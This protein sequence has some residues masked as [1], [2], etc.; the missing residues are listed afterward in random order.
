VRGGGSRADLAAFDAERVARAIATFPMPVWTGIGH[1]GD[2]SVAD[3]VANRAFVTPTEC[4]QELTRRL[5]EWW[6]S[7]QR[8][9]AAVA[10]GA[11]AV[12][13]TASSHDAAARL[14]LGMATRNQ[15]HRH[16]QRVDERTGRI[17]LQSR[18][19]LEEAMVALHQRTVRLGTRARNVCDREQDRV[20][21]WRRLL[22]AYDIDRQLE[23]GYTITLGAD[24][25][26][27]RAAAELV[28][29]AALVTRF[30][31]GEARSTVDTVDVRFSSGG[32]RP[33]RSDQHAPEPSGEK[34]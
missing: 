23:R 31:D 19:H 7:I 2:Q 33:R 16:A 25:H 28:P 9:A 1:S 15:L 29:G 8:A 4:G 27:I 3:I 6:Q 22:A 10:R 17:A 20:A 21:T 18:R 14:R 30:S 26:V 32:T 12:L 13:H 24:G 11:T 5:S 34:P